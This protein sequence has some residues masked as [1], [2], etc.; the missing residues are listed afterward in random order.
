MRCSFPFA[1]VI[2][3]PIAHLGGVFLPEVRGEIFP[4]QND[5]VSRSNAF[6]QEIRDNLW[7]FNTGTTT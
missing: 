1:A 3:L 5:R 4:V 6:E 2:A 7:D